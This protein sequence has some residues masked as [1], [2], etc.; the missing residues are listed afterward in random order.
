MRTC[1]LAFLYAAS[2][3]SFSVKP[4]VACSNCRLISASRLPRLLT[5]APSCRNHRVR[6]CEHATGGAAVTACN[7]SHDRFAPGFKHARAQVRTDTH[8]VLR[9]LS[10]HHT[11]ALSPHHTHARWVPDTS[12]VH[13]GLLPCQGMRTAHLP[14]GCSARATHTCHVRKR[15][16]LRGHGRQE[17]GAAKTPH[18][19]GAAEARCQGQSPICRSTRLTQWRGFPPLETVRRM[20]CPLP[21]ITPSMDF[22]SVKGVVHG[23]RGQQLGFAL[24]YP[25]HRNVMHLHSRQSSCAARVSTGEPFT[26][27]QDRARQVT[28]AHP[29]S[30]AIHN[31]PRRGGWR[32]IKYTPQRWVVRLLGSCLV[33]RRTALP[34]SIILA[35]FLMP[36]MCFTGSSPT[37]L[38][39]LPC[40]CH[41]HSCAH[42]TPKP[43]RSD[44]T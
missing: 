20:H 33:A 43:G 32:N 4:C 36:G 38:S 41:G 44:H 9:A 6:G 3:I 29:E 14:P 21:Y 35:L 11:H 10:P 42:A 40:S 31:T 12:Q 15:A 27:D 28:T 7:S 34:R 24:T 1:F 13:A 17:E 19:E 22:S 8:P 18:A 37:V 23:R 2:V 26:M 30:I 25:S 5:S 39:A 16:P